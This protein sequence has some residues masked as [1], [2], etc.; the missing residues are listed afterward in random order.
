MNFFVETFYRCSEILYIVVKNHVFEATKLNTD[1]WREY[2]TFK[3][4]VEHY[5]VNHNRN[6]VDPLTWANTK[7]TEFTWEFIKREF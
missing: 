1:S 3:H 7:F 6:F 4:W 5:T 2:N